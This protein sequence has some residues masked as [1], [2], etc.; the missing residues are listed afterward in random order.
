MYAIPLN[1]RFSLCSCPIKFQ[2]RFIIKSPETLFKTLA[3][4]HVS[5]RFWR[6][7]THP[8]GRVARAGKVRPTLTLRNSG[9]S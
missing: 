1:W 3:P 4:G 8:M 9:P 2:P 5:E 6:T 7:G